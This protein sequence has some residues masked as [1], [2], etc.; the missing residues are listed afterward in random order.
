MI[1]NNEL[2]MNIIKITALLSNK[3]RNME[4]IKKI[5][6]EIDDEEKLK[7]YIY[8]IIRFVT[9][10]NDDYKNANNKIDFNIF[11]ELIDMNN[12]YL[13]TNEEIE[14]LYMDTGLAGVDYY[15]TKRMN[16]LFNLILKHESNKVICNF[17]ISMYLKAIDMKEDYVYKNSDKVLKLLEI[18]DSYSLND[19]VN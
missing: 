4:E 14:F 11:K 6:L 9:V 1:N 15:T 2:L 13:F 16:D 12:Y 18:I 10:Y 5:N 17:F 7:T 19:N 3:P 8:K